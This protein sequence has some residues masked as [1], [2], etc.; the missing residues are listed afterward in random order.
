MSFPFFIEDQPLQSN[1]LDLFSPIFRQT[2]QAHLPCDGV[3]FVGPQ[4]SGDGLPAPLKAGVEVVRSGLQPVK[5][6]GPDPALYVPLWSGDELCGVAVLAG[7]A[8]EVLDLPAARLLERSRALSREMAL[9]KQAALDPVTGFGNSR[10]LQGNLAALLAHGQ[11]GQS[12]S[13]LLLEVLPR[14]KDSGRALAAIQKSGASLH[15]LI[16]HLASPCHLGNGVFALLWEGV[17]EEQA[18]KMADQLLQWQKREQGGQAHIGLVAFGGDSGGVADIL[19]MAW[20]ALKTARSRGPFGLCPYA[21]VAGRAEHPLSPPLARI[22]QRLRR[23]WQGEACFALIE[24]KNDGDEGIFPE[25]ELVK[26]NA[27]ASIIEVSPQQGYVFVPC[28][29][30]KDAEEWCRAAQAILS[31]QKVSFSMGVAYYPTHTFKKV[32]MVAN[33]RKALLHTAFFGAATF[34]LFDGV[35]LN[36]SGDIYYNEG[37]MARA[38]REYQHGLQLD[39]KNVNL[40]NSL[41]VTFAQMTRYKK[42]IP[43]FEKVLEIDRSNF[44]ALCNVGFAQLAS[45]LSVD[46]IVSFEEAIAC[47]DDYFDLLL[48]LG[49]LYLV[50][51]RYEEAV[52]V[53]EKAEEVGPAGIRDVSHGAVH[54]YLGEACF[55]M[56]RH[57]QAM[58]SLQRAVRY[59]ARDAASLSLLGSLY[60]QEGEGSDIARTFCAQAVEIDDLDWQHWL[61]LGRVELLSGEIT[62]AQKA[63]QESMRLQPRMVDTFLLQAEIFVAT[64]E[65]GAAKAAYEKALKIDGENEQAK[66]GLAGLQKKGSVA[67]S[68]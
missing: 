68:S 24:W 53:L 65:G 4:V 18:L 47:R 8:S 23:L 22:I 38:A 14:E 34:T 7:V 59:N 12:H 33:C 39:P 67:K 50:A 48:H 31:E 58:A 41:G 63:V 55:A 56:G 43:L 17:Q 3:Y 45:D 15:S 29:A 51:L 60:S 54:R 25:Q 6:N 28:S 35:S 11:D 44:M 64:D 42:A 5:D 9:V 32:E 13:L 49:K 19:E 40:L 37:D 52:A 61:R 62:A 16:G 26:I 27:Q 20:Q 1:D 21:S 36:I 66:Q 30:E 57:R 46:A 10:L 2:M